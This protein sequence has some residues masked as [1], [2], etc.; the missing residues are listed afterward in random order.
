MNSFYSLYRQK[1]CRT[2]FHTD[3]S[4]Q[5]TCELHPLCRP[6]KDGNISCC[7][8][9]DASSGCNYIDEENIPFRW[10]QVC[11]SVI[12]HTLCHQS[13]QTLNEDNLDCLLEDGCI[14]YEACTITLIT[15]QNYCMLH[16]LIHSKYSI[17]IFFFVAFS[18]V[19]RVN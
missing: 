10:A 19:L 18:V 17:N 9:R 3:S 14:K 13:V 1:T 2:K 4:S 12:S 15:L 16:L 7:S 11:P 8:G 6:D 5:T